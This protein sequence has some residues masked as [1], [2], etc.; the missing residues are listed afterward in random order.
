MAEETITTKPNL[1][2]VKHSPPIPLPEEG[3]REEDVSAFDR[4]LRESLGETGSVQYTVQ[5]KIQGIAVRI[6]YESGALCR[7]ATIG[8]GHEGELITDNIKTILT[9]PLTLWRIGDA[10][11]FPERL[12]VRGEVYM[13]SADLEGL[14]RERKEKG[15]APF[16]D[17]RQGAQD[18][19]R[20]V[21]PRISA[22][23]PLNMFC[24]E[25][26]DV[27]PSFPVTSLE[28]MVLLQAWGFRVNKPHIRVCDGPDDLI[29]ACRAI[30]EKAFP[31]FTEGAL[32]QVNRLDFGTPEGS[33][34]NVPARAFVYRG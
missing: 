3:Y 5:P 10:P 14:N 30:R 7:A 33:R 28:M 1:E 15:L 8:N 29:K 19:L 25:V 9:V 21:N 4:K 32:I 17:A 27:A 23:R 16:Q 31:F 13:E 18:S 20:Q 22:R 11:P 12:E 6:A 24:Y 34:D 2:R 26:D